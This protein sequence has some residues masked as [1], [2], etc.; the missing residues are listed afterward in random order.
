MEELKHAYKFKSKNLKEGGHLEDPDVDRKITL[1]LI[2]EKV[3]SV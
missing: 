3:Q 2:L 1:K